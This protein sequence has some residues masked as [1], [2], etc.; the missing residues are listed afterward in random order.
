LSLC[1]GGGISEIRVLSKPKCGGKKFEVGTMI[2]S[3]EGYY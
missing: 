3:L 1:K 2:L